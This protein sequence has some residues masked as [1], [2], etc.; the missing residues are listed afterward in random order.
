METKIIRSR[1]KTLSLEIKEDATL[2]IRAPQHI[3]HQHILRIIEKKR[4]WIERK[5][6][7]TRKSIPLAKE[8]LKY[9]QQKAAQLIPQRAEYYAAAHR[10]KYKRIRINDAQKRLGSCS[11]KGNLNFSWRIILAPL[12]V[13]DY[14]VCHELAHLIE[15]NHSHKFWG[16]VEELYPNYKA[17]KKWLKENG[18]VKINIS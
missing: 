6:S 10:L 4:P 13:I 15:K 9:Y 11:S 18:Y 7:Q 3:P 8:E 14:I 16:K 1:R 17:C 5:R 2:I 12:P